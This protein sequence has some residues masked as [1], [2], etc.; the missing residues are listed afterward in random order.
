MKAFFDT[1]VLVAVFRGD[2]EHH[3][4]SLRVFASS[5]TK[6]TAC[7]LHTLAELFAVLTALPVKPPIS[8]EHV[9]LFVDEIRARLT[10]ISLDSQDYY[11]TLG[12]AAERGL[13]DGRIY[14]ALL[15]RCARKCHAQTIYTWNL[16]HFKAIAPD[17]ATRLRM[18]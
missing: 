11:Q 16:R 13:F 6:D 14:D 18:P 1:S 12:A 5:T 10:P 2:H 3:E 7:S 15:L 9:M 17:L 4:R 8:P